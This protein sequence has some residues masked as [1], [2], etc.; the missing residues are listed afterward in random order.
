MPPLAPLKPSLAEVL[1]ALSLYLS[2]SIASYCRRTTSPPWSV[3]ERSAKRREKLLFQP[4]S[5]DFASSPASPISAA[6]VAEQALD[7][8]DMTPAQLLQEVKKEGN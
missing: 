5:E 2:P 8:F 6:E 4:G 1:A 7:A 3:T